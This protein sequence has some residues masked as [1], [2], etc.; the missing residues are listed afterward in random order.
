MRILFAIT[1][2]HV[3]L[4]AIKNGSKII[5]KYKA[6]LCLCPGDYSWFGS[7]SEDALEL[8]NKYPIPVYLIHGN[9]EYLEHAK[10]D[11]KPHKNI[12][13]IHKKSVVDGKVFILAYGG[14]GFAQNDSTFM[15]FAKEEIKKNKNKLFS[16]LMTHGPP[17]GTLL[18]IRIVNY[19]GNKDYTKF[20]KNSKIDF[21]V[22]GHIHEGEG[23]TDQVGTG[24]VAN[25]SYRGMIYVL[26]DEKLPQNE[27][28]KQ[29]ND[30]KQFKNHQKIFLEHV[31]VVNIWD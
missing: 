7:G 14:G 31:C 4:D 1:D 11:V 9:H 8:L 28:E 23:L 2:M 16:I 24:I 17:Y 19:V 10:V 5:K 13:F 25:P 29:V 21:A 18:D 27:F 12:K 3:D 30:L 15:K 22:S 26:N 20:I 6:D